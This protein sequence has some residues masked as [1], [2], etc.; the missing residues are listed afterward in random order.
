V[1]LSGTVPSTALRSRA[2]RITEGVPGVRVVVDH[3]GIEVEAGARMTDEEIARIAAHALD[4]H[5]DVPAGVTATVEDGCVI[6]HGHVPWASQREAAELA[7]RAVPG[8]RGV[9]NLISLQPPAGE[10]PAVSPRSL[11]RLRSL[12]HG[13][14]A[15]ED[16]LADCELY[17]EGLVHQVE[18]A[19]TARARELALSMIRQLVSE[20]WDEARQRWVIDPNPVLERVRRDHGLSLT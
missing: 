8:A 12:D 14:V 1:T 17:L 3:L 6:L 9:R 7:V 5:T 18:I 13:W 20:R 15:V 16:T 11:Y 10:G 2:V 19:P 4:C